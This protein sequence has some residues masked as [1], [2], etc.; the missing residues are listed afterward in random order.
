MNVSEINAVLGLLS[1]AAFV[2]FWVLW[3]Y[4]DAVS[5]AGAVA[6]TAAVGALAGIAVL[7]PDIWPIALGLAMGA[8][9]DFALTQRGAA[10]FLAGM[11]AF[12]L[13]HLAY[14]AMFWSSHMAFAALTP[15]HVAAVSGVLVLA[16]S[17]EAWLAPRTGALRWAV[18]GY[19]GVIALMAAA[20]ITLAPQNGPGVIHAGVG[21]FLLSDVLLAL[22]LFVV[23]D[24]AHQRALALSLTL[25]P[26]YW[27]GQALI[28]MGAAAYWAP[29]NG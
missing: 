10:A 16:A 13:G 20:A 5:L 15:W 3:S 17:T 7:T 25:W 12:A 14:A 8:M 29:V 1:C 27:L 21:L 18:R 23:R 11:A 28:L 6:K 2:A 9:G 24:P 19:V 22:R 26:A 4:R